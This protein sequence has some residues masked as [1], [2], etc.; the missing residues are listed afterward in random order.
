MSVEQLEL[1]FKVVITGAS[2]F[3]GRALL[4]LLSPENISITGVTRSR[5][6]GLV[7]VS[8]YAETPMPDGAVLVH[9]AQGRDASG[10]FDDGDIELCQMLSNRPW[11]HIVYASSAIV[12]GDAKKY[13]R[14]PEELVT[15]TSDYIRVKIA[16][17]EIISNVGGTCLRFANLYGPG[18]GENSVIS[19][20]LRQIPG[21]GPLKLR[22]VSPTRDFLWIE[23]A[24]RCL[25]AACRT[26]P[27]GVLNAGSGCSM[28]VGDVARLALT[29]AGESSRPVIGMGS[30]G[31]A[32]YLT[33]DITKTR[34]TLNWSPEVDISTGLSSLLRMK[35]NDE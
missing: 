31:R 22:D 23:D 35:K 17:E 34:S 20:I 10:A 11:R 7:T 12:Y 14:Q 1:P 19:D 15:A 29:L 27:G 24:A 33:L 32:S 6:P 26:M 8:N 3:I 25:S 5:L 13:L 4:N 16:C 28:A 21:D 30:S 9:L 18:M 2:G